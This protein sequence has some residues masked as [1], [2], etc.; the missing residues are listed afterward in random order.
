MTTHRLI[1][2]VEE[3]CARYRPRL[4]RDGLFND[5]YRQIR[6]NWLRRE[7]GRW[8]SD[9]NWELRVERQ[10][11][12]NPTH[13]REKQ[14]QK[15]IAICLEGDDW[16]NDMPTASGLV[17]RWGRQMNIDIAHQ[18]GGGFELFEVKVTSDTPYDAACQVLRYGAIYMLY[19]LEPELAMRFRDKPVIRAKHIALKVIA[20]HRYYR[21]SDVDLTVF[22]NQV[23]IQL[24]KFVLRHAAEVELSF[25]FLAFPPDFDY[26][27]GIDCESIRDAIQ[28]RASPLSRRRERSS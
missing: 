4:Q 12:P 2:G 26:Q 8:P 14:L 19:R 16:G 23:N 1:E 27:P 25:Q 24:K 3:M 9:K 5:I 28:R 11:T 22:E 13:R 21:R 15:Q 10:F 18:A 7:P 6:Q 17:D 20:P